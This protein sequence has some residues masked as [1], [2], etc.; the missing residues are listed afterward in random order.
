MFDTIFLRQILPLIH[1]LCCLKIHGYLPHKIKWST[2]QRK[3][4]A[5]SVLSKLNYISFS[6]FDFMYM[7]KI[8]SLGKFLLVKISFMNEEQWMNMLVNKH[9][10]LYKVQNVAY[11]LIDSNMYI[12]IC[13]YEQES[14]PHT[15]KAQSIVQPMSI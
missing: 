3:C 8:C 11:R 1:N 2:I 5:S 9:H 4:T 7:H 15:P 13:M 14:S 6:L 12:Y 10:V